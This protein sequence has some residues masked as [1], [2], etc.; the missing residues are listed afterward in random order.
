MNGERRT[1][2][3]E[4]RS[5]QPTFVRATAGDVDVLGGLMREFYAIEHLRFDEAAARA[6][7]QQAFADPSAG[8]V[9]LIEIEAVPN[10]YFVIGFNFSLEFH[11]RYAWLDE[12]YVREPFRGR[13]AGGAA[14]RFVEQSCREEGL[15]A[16]RLEVAR[17]NAGAASLYRRSGYADSNRDLLTKWIR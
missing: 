10:G 13:G 2:K 17:E 4:R 1:E 7:L 3:D 12:L 9:Y 16:V 6:A 5:A 14:L 11:G 8:T 15:V